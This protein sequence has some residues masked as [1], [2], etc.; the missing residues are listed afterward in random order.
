MADDPLYERF[1]SEFPAGHELFREGDSGKEMY[2]IQSG[3]VR[4]SKQVRDVETT[5]VTL[6]PGE[7]FGEMSILNNEP[8]SASATVDAPAKLL[9]ID[10]R[11]FEAMVRGNAEIAVRMIK[12]LAARLQ[13]ADSQIENLL[14][15]DHNSRVVHIL[16]HLANKQGRPCDEGI[17]VDVAVKDLASKIG[18]EVEPVNEV[19]NKLIRA[20]L[21]KIN[22]T[23][24]VIQDVAKLREFLEFLEMKEKFGDI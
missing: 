18:I 15:R 7:F 8:R 5:L 4:I 14:L 1:G 23:G 13:E 12:K 17:A 20:K 11:T 21:I 19:L 2:V 10:P 16:T 24:V 3:K 9:V 22:E 6:G